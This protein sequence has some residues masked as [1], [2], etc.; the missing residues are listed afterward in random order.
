MRLMQGEKK[1]SP[2]IKTTAVSEFKEV[3]EAVKKLKG[4]KRK[5][6]KLTLKG[7]FMSRPNKSV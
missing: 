4:K 2:H 3:V 5:K 6:G 7:A 1:S